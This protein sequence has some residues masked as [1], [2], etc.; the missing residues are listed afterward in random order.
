MMEELRGY[1]FR[2]YLQTRVHD[3]WFSFKL[4]APKAVRAYYLPAG[5]TDPLYYPVILLRHKR[6][7]F[8]G[9]VPL[10]FYNSRK[11]KSPIIP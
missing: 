8:K 4:T 11:I 5:H 1:E 9:S 2:N 3:C 7:Q 6:L 10:H